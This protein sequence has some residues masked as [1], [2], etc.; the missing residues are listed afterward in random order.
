MFMDEVMSVFDNCMQKI[1]IES[2]DCMQ[3]MCFVIVYCL[4]MICNVDCICYFDKG[5]FVEIGSYD[6]LMEKCGLFYELVS[7]QIVDDY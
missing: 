5:C 4:S 1:V 2:M 7:C 6:E 3:V